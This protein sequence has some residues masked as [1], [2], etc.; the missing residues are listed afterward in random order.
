MTPSA[1]R[2]TATGSLDPDDSVLPKAQ[3]SIAVSTGQADPGL[4]EANLRDERYLPFEGARADDSTWT[5]DLAKEFPPFDY[6]T[7]ADL[8]LH[9]R[10]TARAGGTSREGLLQTQLNDIAGDGK[11]VWRTFSLRREF[12]S[13]WHQLIASGSSEI[14]MTV[15]HFGYLLRGRSLTL[16]EI[17]GAA[18]LQK[19]RDED[20]DLILTVSAGA[21]LGTL[22]MAMPVATTRDVLKGSLRLPTPIE[23]T[24]AS[25]EVK[26]H[27]VL[28]TGASEVPVADIEDIFLTIRF[29]I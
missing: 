9:I 24:S 5:F 4:F 21:A 6:E 27:L 13:S 17:E 14:T 15:S 22:K 29:S 11:G 1:K 7:I 28:K 3:L 26:L 2:R 19:A 10:Y 16:Q 23:M 12:S 25:P 18:F 8:V 20:V